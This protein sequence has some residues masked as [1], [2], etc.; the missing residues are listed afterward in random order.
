VGSVPGPACFARGGDQV[1][2]TDAAVALGLLDPTTFLNGALALDGARAA[3]ALD[4]H[5]G[6]PLGIG[7]LEAAQRLK[8]AWTARIAEAI[9]RLCPVGPTTGLLAFG[10]GGPMFAT[11]IADRIGCKT[12]VIPALAPVFSAFGIGFSAHGHDY[13]RH[14]GDVRE[15]VVADVLAAIEETARRDL[16]GEGL[17]I[18]ACRRTI[19]CFGTDGVPRVVAD[20]KEIARSAPDGGGLTLRV[21]YHTP[22]PSPRYDMGPVAVGA[23]APQAGTRSVVLGGSALPLPVHRV[24]TLGPGAFAVGPC[25]VED[26]YFT[27]LIDEGWQFVSQVGGD[28][29][30]RRM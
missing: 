14:L 10:G 9:E 28:L 29:L 2:I 17:A 22:L 4:R 13:V 26:A 3:A 25:V 1:T 5:I 18:E 23:P 24:E 20:A 8:D 12:V 15:D 27:A 21:A 30:L 7:T 19:Q 11:A 16:F 6:G